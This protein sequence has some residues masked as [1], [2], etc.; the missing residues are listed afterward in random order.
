MRFSLN[1]DLYFIQ[2]CV[3]FATETGTSARYARKLDYILRK[4]FKPELRNLKDISVKDLS[5]AAQTGKWSPERR[6]L[7][8]PLFTFSIC[9]P[10]GFGS[11]DTLSLFVVS[12]F[13]SGVCPTG[14]EPFQEE[15]ARAVDKR[16]RFLGWGHNSMKNSFSGR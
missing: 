13:G 14:V 6:D 7:S 11:E 1:V 4:S 5:T 16:K 3:Y 9:P 8:F 12:T 2:V 10:D 15:L